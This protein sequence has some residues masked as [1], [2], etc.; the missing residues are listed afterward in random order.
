MLSADLA[1]I[2]SQ[3]T[4]VIEG[5]PLLLQLSLGPHLYQ[6]SFLNRPASLSGWYVLLL[7]TNCVLNTRL[8]TGSLE[9][10]CS[11]SSNRVTMICVPESSWSRLSYHCAF[12]SVEVECV[13]PCSVLLHVMLCYCQ[14]MLT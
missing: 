5:V 4:S 6:C 3:I 13:L 12:V 2:G 9:D 10:V 1:Q 8:V 14:L 11:G 7:T